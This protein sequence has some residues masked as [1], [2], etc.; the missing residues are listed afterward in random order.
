MIN[1]ALREY[2]AR[3]FTCCAVDFESFNPEAAVFWPRHFTPVGHSLVRV[4]EN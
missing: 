1:A 4:P 3:G 2:A